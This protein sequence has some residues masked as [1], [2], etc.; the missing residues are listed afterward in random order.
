MRNKKSLIT[1]FALF[2]LLSVSAQET[3]T[4]DQCR[5]LAKKNNITLKIDQLSIEEASQIRKESFTNFFPK[6]SATG[7]GYY[8]KDGLLGK[9]FSAILGLPDMKKGYLAEITVEQPIFAGGQI[10]YGNKLAQV[11]EET[12]HYQSAE[13]EKNTMLA[14]E[15][16]YWTLIS[17]YEKRQTILIM[18]DLA[19]SLHKDVKVAVDAGV[20]NRNDLLKIELKQ[21]EIKN[22]SL[23]LEN[24]IKLIKMQLAQIVGI[25]DANF[26]IQESA[27]KEL[28]DPQLFWINHNQALLN[29]NSYHLLSKNIEVSQLKLKMKRGE[30]LPSIGVGASYSYSDIFSNRGYSSTMLYLSVSIPISDWW[31]GSHAIKQQKAQVKMAEYAKRD[32][33]QKILIQMQK[34]Q[35]MLDEAYHKALLA[36]QAIETAQENVRLNTDSY[37]SGLSIISDLIDAQSLLQ[38]SRDKYTEAC[39][40]YL[41]CQS[42]YLKE[43]GR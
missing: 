23:E 21:N 28:I 14:V 39:T 29:T 16:Y 2:A 20:T 33:E 27:S 30:Y 42:I 24:G 38:Q 43:T 18:D 32:S 4:L 22:S 10:Y 7:M 6:V 15:Q 19:T 35:N 37:K 8:T 25:P 1:F 13:S 41:I 34:Y 17:L 9:D 40:N 26:N 3:Y 5:E 36:K 11:G 31:G 12:S